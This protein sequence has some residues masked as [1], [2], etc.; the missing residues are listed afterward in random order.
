MC[1]QVLRTA[2]QIPGLHP[3]LLRSFC[4]SDVRRA[5]TTEVPHCVLIPAFGLGLEHLGLDD[6]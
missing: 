4:R 1:A 3:V 2:A 6:V 5:A